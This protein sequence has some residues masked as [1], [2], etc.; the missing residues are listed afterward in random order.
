MTLQN[1]QV[2]S[3]DFKKVDHHKASILYLN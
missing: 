2:Y 1:L 3:R